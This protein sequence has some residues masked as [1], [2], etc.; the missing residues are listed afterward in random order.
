VIPT[1][2]NLFE[3]VCMPSMMEN[4]RPT[5]HVRGWQETAR[6]AKKFLF[7]AQPFDWKGIQWTLLSQIKT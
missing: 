5:D 3:G 2:S 7:W 6:P 1:N 4:Q